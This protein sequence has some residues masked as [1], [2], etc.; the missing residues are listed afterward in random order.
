[1]AQLL[2]RCVIEGVRASMVAHGVAVARDEFGP[3]TEASAA[4]SVKSTHYGALLS[5]AL[6]FFPSPPLFVCV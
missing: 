2:E 1:V 5:R 4:A 3:L 6:S